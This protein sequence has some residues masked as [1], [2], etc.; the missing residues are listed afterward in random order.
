MKETTLE[1]RRHK[2]EVDDILKE[3]IHADL[4]HNRLKIA[5]NK[6]CPLCM[7][8]E[9]GNIG[10][11]QIKI[12]PYGKFLSCNQYPECNFTW[13]SPSLIGETPNQKQNSDV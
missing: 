11:L 2:K 4:L 7:K 8:R 6:E 9:G 5:N 1:E 13:T 10:I 12:G 3:G